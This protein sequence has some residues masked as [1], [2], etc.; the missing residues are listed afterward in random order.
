MDTE[1]SPTEN[2]YRNK[3]WKRRNYRRL[4]SKTPQKRRVKIV[5]LG[6]KLRQRHLRIIKMASPLKLFRKLKSGYISLM[7]AVTGY[8]SNRKH[9]GGAQIEVAPPVSAEVALANRV[10]QKKMVYEIFKSI[11]STH[12]M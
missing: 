1:S 9:L 8:A 3:N 7:L 12:G 11:L 2:G 5:R 4:N 6:G 10:F